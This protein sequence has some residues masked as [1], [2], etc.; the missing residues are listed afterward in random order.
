MDQGGKD[1]PRILD[2]ELGRARVRVGFNPAEMGMAPL[3]LDVLVPG[4]PVPADFF[5]PIYRKESGGIE[6]TLAASK[7]EPYR[8]AWRDRL[9]KTNQTR[10]F[11]RM[12]DGEAINQYFDRHA[13]EIVDNPN[14]PLS[15]KR[16]LLKEMANLNLRVL[17]GGDLSPRALDSSVKRAH[18]TVSRLAREAQI[19]TR[20]SE[21]VSADYS[22]YSHSVNVCMLAMAF[23]R[24]MGFPEAR[25]Q[26]LGVGGML[27]DVGWARLPQGLLDNPGPYSPKEE[28]VIRRHPE[29]GYKMLLPIGAVP[30]DV[31]M[32]VRH[33]HENADGSGYPARLPADKTPYLARVIKIADVYD[34]LTTQSA[35]QEALSPREAAA[36]LLEGMSD[37]FGSDLTL[38]FVRFLGSPAF[39]Q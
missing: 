17:F 26:T 39:T 2:K 11:I 35:R 25:V 12:E 33:H 18:E 13:S 24:Y 8:A 20:L 38:P 34:R 30:Y 31:L 32:I 22:V 6:M 29:L 23:G 3:N 36:E 7:G 37:Q 10:V 27:H 1:S 15:K 9:K 28:A 21:V 16:R 5:L 4:H 19:L 14:T